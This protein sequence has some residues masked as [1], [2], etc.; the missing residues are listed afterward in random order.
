MTQWLR[1]NGF[2]EASKDT[3]DQLMREECM[4]GFIRGR[5]AR[6][7]IPGKEDG[8][9]AGDLPADGTVAARTRPPGTGR[10]DSP[11][12][13]GKPTHLDP[14]HGYPGLGGPAALHWNGDYCADVPGDMCEAGC[15]LDQITMS[16]GSVLFVGDRL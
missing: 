7:S 11:Q 4:N 14:L 1:R 2:P 5:R 16:G 15:G 9:R 3:G 12:R 10:T 8:R 6:T 13:C